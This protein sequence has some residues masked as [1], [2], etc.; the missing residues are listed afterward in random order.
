MDYMLI[1]VPFQYHFNYN[2]N[3]GIKADYEKDNA[4]SVG[5]TEEKPR[6]FAGDECLQIHRLHSASI[7]R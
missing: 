6:V 3:R 4:S 1:K 2:R 5:A 7:L